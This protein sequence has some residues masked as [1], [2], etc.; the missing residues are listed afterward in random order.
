MNET[1][2]VDHIKYGRHVVLESLE[3]IGTTVALACYL[4]VTYGVG[5]VPSI[6]PLDYD[7]P[8]DYLV[9]S[10]AIALIKK[11]LWIFPKSN[12]A[13]DEALRVFLA[14]EAKNRETNQTFRKRQFS[15]CHRSILETARNFAFRILGPSPF[16]TVPDFG[17]GATYS[18]KGKKSTLVDKL[19]GLPECTNLAHDQVLY[20]I[21]DRM[22][23]YAVSSGIVSRDRTSVSLRRRHLPIVPGNRLTFVPKTSDVSRPIC[24]EPCGNLL[25][26]KAYGNSIRTKLRKFGLDITD[27]GYSDAKAQALHRTLAKESSINGINA[28]IDLSSASDTMSSEFVKFLLPD[29]WFFALNSVRSHRTRLP[30][31]ST[32]LNEKFSSMG[33]GFTFELET[34]LFFC[35]VLACSD[36]LGHPCEPKVFG[37][38][39]I[40]PTQIAPLVVE[41]LGVCG[42]STNK[43]KTFLDGPFRESCGGDYLR[44]VPVRPIFLRINQDEKPLEFTINLLNFIRRMAGNLC[45]NAYLHP[46]FKGLWTRTLRR[47][48][49]NSQIFGPSNRDGCVHTSWRGFRSKAEARHRIF[50]RVT[51]RKILPTTPEGT[52]AYALY[53]LDSNGISPRGSDYLFRPGYTKFFRE[54]FDTLRWLP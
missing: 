24:V 45:D 43:S 37:D 50:K 8:Y 28:T 23:A 35:L 22:P 6:S 39:I 41:I 47:I 12:S 49:K 5:Y 32:I 44:G 1:K 51:R 30:D 46:S 34:L 20:T 18:F 25:L 40:C 36:Y 9:D 42:F 54:D 2:S 52:M 15:F 26:Q 11:N 53:G 10:Q 38:D 27:D 3:I 21:L 19:E 7:S 31:G 17:P 48:G 29:D 14:C 16:L 13:D 33:N 4:S